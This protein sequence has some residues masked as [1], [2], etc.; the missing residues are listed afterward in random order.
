MCFYSGLEATILKIGSVCFSYSYFLG[1]TSGLM[2]IGWRAANMSLMS[3]C[4]LLDCAH[5]TYKRYAS[6][7]RPTLTFIQRFVLGRSV[8]TAKPL[9]LFW[10]KVYSIE[11]FLLSSLSVVWV[12]W[13]SKTV[14]QITIDFFQNCDVPQ[15][16]SGSFDPEVD[17]NDDAFGRSRF[18]R[19]YSVCIRIMR[20]KI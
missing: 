15:E 17:L 20:Q 4:A 3:S 6:C 19:F 8:P 1:S 12:P 10:N 13:R 16:V 9:L 14:E 11:C 18:K 2:L 7:G 5:I